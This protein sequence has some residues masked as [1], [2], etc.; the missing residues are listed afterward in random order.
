MSN[1]QHQR[2]R[3]DVPAANVVDA[4]DLPTDVSVTP[5]FSDGQSRLQSPDVKITGKDSI[6][7]RM[8]ERNDSS[9]RGA[10]VELRQL[11]ESFGSGRFLQVPPPSAAASAAAPVGKENQASGPSPMGG[12]PFAALL[13]SLRKMNPEL[14]GGRGRS[15][16]PALPPT[17][18]RLLRLQSPQP[19]DFPAKL[20]GLISSPRLAWDS[21][22]HRPL[23]QDYQPLTFASEPFRKMPPSEDNFPLLHLSEDNFPPRGHAAEYS[24]GLLPFPMLRMVDPHHR[25]VPFFVPPENIVGHNNNNRETSTARSELMSARFDEPQTG[26]SDVQRSIKLLQLEPCMSRSDDVPE[27][28]SDSR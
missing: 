27:N 3:N 11:R 17:R 5:I 26:R 20:P 23:R 9:I 2:G 4:V 21:L 25:Q 22:D 28:D 8:K 13:D 15:M 16:L 24:D 12:R 10:L 18:L 6:E 14:G 7:G 19:N 1:T